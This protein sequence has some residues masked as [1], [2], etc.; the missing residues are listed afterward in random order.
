MKPKIVSV[1]SGVG[2]IDFGFEKAGFETVFASDIWSKACE[3]LKVNFPNSEIVCDTIENVDFKKIKRKHKAID[4]LVGGPPCPPFSKSRFYRK[5]KERGIDDEDGFM[6]V[7][8]YFRAVEE[9]APK[10][11]FFENVHG[12]VFKPHQT[13][14]E[15]VEKESG[16]LGY[17]IFHNVLNA[18]DF[19]VAQTRQRFICIGVKKSMVDFKFPKQTHSDPTKPIKGTKPWVTCGD[20][21]N[22]IDI[23][24]PEDIKMIA[25]SKH[26]DLLKLIPPGDNYLFFTKERNHPN[27]LFKWR[28]RY[29]SFLLKLSPNRPSWTIQASHSN[30]MGPFHWKNRFLRIEEIKRIQSFEDKHIFLGSY[31]EQWRQV[32]NAVP[33]KLAFEIASE[34][35]RQFFLNTNS[36]QIKNKQYAKAST[37]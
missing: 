10:F 3:S 22:D 31:K 14:L 4:G 6:T 24:T 16:R 36:N 19:G 37:T 13:A 12:F 18:A 15:L 34:I 27:P 29:W 20:I 5:E 33:P 8:N 7:T 9:L 25:G 28:S 17:K 23:D 11:F 26:K 35:Y 1:F 2:G 32:G 21:L 30:N